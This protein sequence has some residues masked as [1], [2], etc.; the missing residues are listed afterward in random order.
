[1]IIQCEQCS[2]KFRLDDSK[3]TAKGVKVRCAKCKHVFSV[4]KEAPDEGESTDF[5]ALLDRAEAPAAAAPS[6]PPPTAPFA[7][8]AGF[9]A[10]GL[11]ESDVS[12]PAQDET[13]Q[14]NL[15]RENV[16]QP[17]EPAAEDYDFGVPA[18]DTGNS[19]PTQPTEEPA[20]FSG[21]NEFDFGSFDLNDNSQPQPSTE[22]TPPSQSG[23]AAAPEDGFDFGS[24]DFSDDGTA[25]SLD[26]APPQ[27]S[28][29]SV[30][31][32]VTTPAEDDAGID[33]GSDNLFGD[34]PASPQAEEP[35]NPIN[36]DF[37]ESFADSLGSRE[38]DRPADA[39]EP[40]ADEPFSLGEIDFGD[41][42][43]AV[44]VQQVN[45][46]ELRPG[47][48]LLFA[49]LGAE[50]IPVNPE[51]AAAPPAAPAVPTS[52]E[53]ELPPLSI[54]SRRKQGPLLSIISAAVGIAA[55]AAIAFYGYTTLKGSP[56]SGVQ[57]GGKISLRSVNAKY[58]SNEASGELLVISGEAVNDY[59]KP[60]ASIQVRGMIYGSDGKI[61]ASKN[62]Y[63]GNPLT[64]EQLATMPMEKIEAAMANQFGD[65]LAN[66]EV[67]PGKAIPFVVVIP[68][69]A[70]G[71][72]EYGVEP[73]GSTVATGKQ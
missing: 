60:R 46:D 3:V 20:V 71:G 55:A 62:A 56:G 70:T 9:T 22:V 8:A 29:P 53:E 32:A 27:K 26:S 40:A 12:A 10:A 48:D 72:K 61:L 36:F 65:S 38:S 45:P 13:V 41:E 14:E 68:Q 67:A 58:V 16:W 4:R 47:Q 50:K 19:A 69:P 35:A 64:P 43:T 34:A 11:A 44:A 6:P 2:T 21:S 18:L 42:L 28:A 51:A 25:D 52:A 23:T 39:A 5:G 33:F 59:K 30:S 66:L 49:P 31:P 15:D 1:M 73:A 7:A 57:E 24:F 17:S 54:S 63:G 37:Q